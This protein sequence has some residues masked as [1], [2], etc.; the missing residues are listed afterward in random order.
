LTEVLPLNRRAD[1]PGIPPSAP[2]FLAFSRRKKGHSSSLF[3]SIM[4]AVLG[5]NYDS[6]FFNVYL[7]ILLDSKCYTTRINGRTV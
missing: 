5:V 1:V 7:G 3:K 2:R 6:I 4:T